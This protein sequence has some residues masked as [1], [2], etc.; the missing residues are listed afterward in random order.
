MSLPSGSSFD[1]AGTN[2]G[3]GADPMVDE[4]GLTKRFIVTLFDAEP[5]AG[6]THLVTAPQ[7]V[8]VREGGT[9][10]TTTA[11]TPRSGCSH[12]P[13]TRTNGQ[14]TTRKHSHNNR[15]EKGGPVSRAD[16]PPQHSG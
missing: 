7:V 13:N 8:F 3:G 14:Q 1:V 4:D 11:H 5:A 6:G 16:D 12:Q 9:T 15:T 2:V 10:T